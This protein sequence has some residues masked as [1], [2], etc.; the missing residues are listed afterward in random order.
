M[1][2][3]IPG[4]ELAGLFYKEAVMPILD[5]RYPGLAHSAALMGPGSEVLGFDSALSRDHGWGPRVD[6]FLSR[7]DHTLLAGEIREAL[8][9][10]LPFTFHGYSTHFEEVPDEPGT[11]VPGVARSRPINHGVCIRTLDTFLRQYTGLPSE[12]EL[13]LRDWLTIPEQKLRT[14]VAGAIYHDALGVLGPMRERLSYYPHDLWLYLLSAQW[15]R[16][17]QEEPFVG[18]AGIAGDEA[19]SAVIA[20]RLVHD[21]MRLCMLM[22]RKY[23]PYSKWFG[24]AFARLKCAPLLMPVLQRVLRADDWQD[25]E[26]GLCLAYS[27]AATL[28]NDLGITAPVPTEVSQF[29]SR[30]FHVIHGESIALAIW[31]C[32]EDAEV[33]ALPYG[34]GKIDQYLDSTDILSNTDHSRRL[35]SLYSEQ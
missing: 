19:G 20:A 32:I 5:S 13:L 17:G 10:E 35:R 4:L 29:Y 34:V 25:R 7:E 23:A 8:G 28:H 16:I 33:R 22:E 24:S 2:D 1:V 18:R 12:G 14:L 11:V 15:Q 26:D 3:F 27:M 31:E 21:L 6:V 9:L 30:P